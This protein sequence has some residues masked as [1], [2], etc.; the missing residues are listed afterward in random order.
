MQ[1]HPLFKKALLT[2]TLTRRREVED[3]VRENPDFFDNYAAF[4]GNPILSSNKKVMLTSN[5]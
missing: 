5:L 3:M 4:M 1:F 2:V